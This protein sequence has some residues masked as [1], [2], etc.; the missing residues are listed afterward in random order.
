MRAIRSQPALRPPHRLGQ[1]VALR[2]ERAGP[3]EGAGGRVVVRGDGKTAAAAAP[4]SGFPR[5]AEGTGD[6]RVAPSAAAP[7]PAAAAA[8]AAASCEPAGSGVAGDGWLGS[9]RLRAA[10]FKARA[11]VLGAGAAAAKEL[12]Y[13]PPEAA[14]PAADGSGAGA[15]PTESTGAGLAGPSGAALGSCLAATGSLSGA[16]P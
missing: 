4:A 5:G 10:G 6:E 16:V 2:P 14:A 9:R 15:P 12:K 11:V 13:G 8:A 3:A 7:A 1:G